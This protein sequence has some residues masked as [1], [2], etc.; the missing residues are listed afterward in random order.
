[1]TAA[2]TACWHCG[3]PLPEGERLLARVAGSHHPVCCQGC[4]A[5]AEWIDQ[6]GLADYYRL[7]STPAQRP[8]A[9]TN[10]P[11]DHAAWTRPEVARHVV[12]ELDD[13][14]RES[15]LLIEGIRCS[16]CVWLIERAL[17]ALDG[18]DSVRINAGAQRAHIV[19]HDN[20][21]ALPRI[22]EVL[23]RTG[24]R[25]L[26]LDAAA[27][28][29]LRQREARAALKRLVVAGFG[30][31]QAMM[32]ASGL[33]LGAFD[34]TGTATRDLL[35]WLGLLVATPVVFYAAR[36]FFTG[37]WRTL[38]A[39]HPGMDVPV[40]LAIALIYAASVI[41][42][43]RG[44]TE[45]YFD[46]VSMFVFFLLVGRYLEMRARHRTGDLCDAM[47]RLTPLFADRIA[48]DGTQQRV[49]ALEL[50][51]GDTVHVAEGGCVPADGR[52][53]SDRCR[54]DEA[55]LSGESA[56][57]LKRRGDALIAG[58]LVVE[59]PAVM[60]VARVGGETVLAGI[61]ALLTRAAAE[62][63]R[64]ARAGERAAA[65]FV[66]R[67]LALAT[68]TAIGWSLIDPSRAF[69]A[70]LAVLVVSCPCAFALAVPA[71]LTR[72][73][74]L[75]ARRG[76]LV[77]RADA[78]EGLAGA[79]HVVF[80]KTGTLTDRRL[81]LEHV[82]CRRDGIDRETAL[83]LAASLARGSRHPVAC[84]IA[85]A[86]T[87]ATGIN[88]GELRTEAGG[89][90]EGLVDGRRLRLGHASFA[91]HGVPAPAPGDE[92]AVVLADDEGP[93][94]RF[95]LGER[96]RPGAREAITALAQDGLDIEIASGDAPGKVADVAAQ[97]GITHW[98]ARLTP[99]AKLARLEALRAGGA[100]V[101]MAGDGINDGPVLAAADIAVT[102]ASGAELA[103]ATSDIILAGERLGLLAEAR[104]MACET[105]TVLRQNQRWALAYNL[106]AVPFAALGMVPPWLAALGMSASSLI[107]V[108]NALRIGGGTAAPDDAP[109]PRGVEA[110]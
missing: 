100:R 46:S 19:W 38:K 55:L 104:A 78:I 105:L 90:L 82:D 70:T 26:P 86:H 41:E 43:L 47:A 45:V 1:M 25:A 34:G 37:A 94:A 17:G 6:L 106:A 36:P 31:M 11:P 62:R 10:G 75:L 44:G 98:R 101:I 81:S 29:E 13:G 76:V 110:C 83:R 91:L 60:D 40:A 24:Y 51:P 59:G 73:I 97:L 21:C 23:A 109:A 53:V 61:V 93:I 89:G 16:A 107:V 57:V 108:L 87:T 95:R 8:D 35:R 30:A 80:D 27:L 12:R 52:L 48:A 33:Y 66:A 3:E 5:A 39:R 9:T 84:A 102:L 103:Q 22:L 2:A 85:A 50:R 67:V 28:D 4:R 88:V 96:L 79:T 49:G 15:T 74:A 20:A 18:I 64:L 77:V 7:R 72:A 42:I 71:A 65:G 92:D 14:R 63:P 56:P 68:L 58:S 99:A 54:V 69:A 32:F